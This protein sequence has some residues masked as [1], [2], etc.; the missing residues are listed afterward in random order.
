MEELCDADWD[1]ENEEKRWRRSWERWM[2]SPQQLLNAKIASMT[3]EELK[4]WEEGEDESDEDES[5]GEVNY[6]D[7]KLELFEKTSEGEPGAKVDFKAQSAAPL[8]DPAP[9]PTAPSALAQPQ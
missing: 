7:F 2:S 8:A 9:L 3:P 6:E 1:M 5:E 4:K